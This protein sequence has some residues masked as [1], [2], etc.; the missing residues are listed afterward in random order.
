MQFN[1][2]RAFEQDASAKAAQAF[3]EGV[4]LLGESVEEARRLISGLRSPV[5]DSAGVVAAIRDFLDPI[6]QHTNVEIQ[7]A[8]NLGAMR[9]AP[10]LETAVFRI[11]Q[12]SVTNARK[13]S[14]SD[15]IRVMLKSTSDSLKV[16]IQ[17]WG[18]GFQSSE[19]SRSSFGLEG[20]QQRARLLGGRVRINTSP[21]EGTRVRVV[22]PM[23]M[24]AR[25]D[26][27][28]P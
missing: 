21:G 5:L 7:F 3:N 2:F 27:W 26:A 22:F 8:E 10:I 12:E 24:P 20:I 15:R 23:M 18:R 1:A 28:E 14:R 19:I 11:V 9:L 4:R 16:E 13:H 6:V 17:D 25:T